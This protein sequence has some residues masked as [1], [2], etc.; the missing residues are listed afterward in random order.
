MNEKA[1]IDGGEYSLIEVISVSDERTKMI[2]CADAAGSKYACPEE[3][4]LR[5]ACQVPIELP[6]PVS[7]NSSTQEKIAC[8]LSMFRGRED[9]YAKRYYSVKTGKIGYT[10]ACKNEWATGI[11][12]K[13]AHKCPECPNRAF[14]TLSAD[15][16]KAHLMGRDPYCRDVVAIYPMLE[17]DTTR[18]LAADFDEAS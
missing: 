8:F 11:C 14:Q 3:V 5:H 7:T 1:I 12:D 17:D 4:W 10:P 6:A 13:K 18:L 16:V 9:L 15:V 2:L